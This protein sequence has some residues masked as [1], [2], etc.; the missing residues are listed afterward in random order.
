MGT[1]F[2]RSFLDSK[3]LVPRKR[4]G[5]SEVDEFGEVEG[6][7]IV[8]REEVVQL[9]SPKAKLM[10][11]VQSARAALYDAEAELIKVLKSLKETEGGQQQQD[12]ATGAGGGDEIVAAEPAAVNSADQLH[13]MMEQFQKAANATVELEAALVLKISVPLEIPYVKKITRRKNKL[14]EH[15]EKWS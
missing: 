12:V 1:R 9:T 2:T 13:L 3:R 6:E 10:N 8:V 5:G 7:E 14:D 15:I 11:L 4:V